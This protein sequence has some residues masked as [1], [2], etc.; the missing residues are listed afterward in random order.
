MRISLPTLLCT[1]MT[2]LAACGTGTERPL[3]GTTGDPSALIE[4]CEEPS[5]ASTIQPIFDASCLQCH[6]AN[7]ALGGLEL[8]SY[9]GVMAGGVSG[10]SVVPGDCAGSDLFQRVSG[11]DASAMPPVGYQPLGEDEVACICAWIAQGCLDD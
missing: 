10:A 2:G 11:Q 5:Y 4:A 6:W 1:M 3:P 8:Q 7:A 9:Q